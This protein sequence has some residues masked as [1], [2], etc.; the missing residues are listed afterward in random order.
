[1]QGQAEQLSKSR[2]KLLATTYTPLFSP[3]DNIY[4][5]YDEG[6]WF[7]FSPKLPYP[8]LGVTDCSLSRCL[9][10]SFEG[11]FDPL[12]TYA[13][14]DSKAVKCAVQIKEIR[15][16]LASLKAQPKSEVIGWKTRIM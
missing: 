3:R 5:S 13:I 6:I 11:T 4:G 7:H 12:N 1:M 10:V 9:S 8:T 2:K 16:N 14:P 15:P